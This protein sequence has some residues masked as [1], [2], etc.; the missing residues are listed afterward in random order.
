MP[1]Y[2]FYCERCRKEVTLTLTVREREASAPT[3]PQ[4]RGP[5]EPLMAA[6]YSK[7]S[8]KS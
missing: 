4:C 2:E 1:T 8:K 3:C 7:T 6:F 5:L